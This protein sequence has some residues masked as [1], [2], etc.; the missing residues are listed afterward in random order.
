MLKIPYSS[1]RRI[2][3]TTTMYH[4]STVL[5]PQS[6]TGILWVGVNCQ[7]DFNATLKGNQY[8]SVRIDEVSFARVGCDSPTVSIPIVTSLATLLSTASAT[9]IV[10]EP[11][12]V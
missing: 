6:D 10:V 8:P 2:T 7:Y 9:P 12:S 5:Y 3:I 1:I 11:T 4:N